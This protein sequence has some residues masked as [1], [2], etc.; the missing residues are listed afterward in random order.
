M[1]QIL[2]TISE[3]TIRYSMSRSKIYDIL[4]HENAPKPL[5]PGKSGLFVI[6]EFDDFI[7]TT[8][9]NREMNERPRRNKNI[10]EELSNYE[11]FQN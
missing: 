6:E 3:A 1:E 2:M 5:K 11:E 10:L 4:K 8:Y 7:F 9:A